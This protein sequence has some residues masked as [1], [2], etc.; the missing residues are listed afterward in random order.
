MPQDNAE[1]SKIGA[2][3]LTAKADN[4]DAPSVLNRSVIGLSVHQTPD[5]V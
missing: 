5:D 1:K 3:R 2:A 4:M